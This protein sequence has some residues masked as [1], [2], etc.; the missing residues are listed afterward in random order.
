[1]KNA[2]KQQNAGYMEAVRLANRLP[3]MLLDYNA[4]IVES[5]HNRIALRDLKRVFRLPAKL[6]DYDAK[7]AQPSDDQTATHD[8]K[9]VC[10]HLAH[11]LAL[12]GDT[13]T[14]EQYRIETPQQPPRHKR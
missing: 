3:Q 13:V 14:E 1:M 5:S 7:I 2:P 11:A 4:E 10:C 12:L 6:L 8:L 9:Q